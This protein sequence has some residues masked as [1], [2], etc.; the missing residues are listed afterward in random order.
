[1]WQKEGR[2]KTRQFYLDTNVFISQL[3][4]DD[5]YHAEALIIGRKLRK[6]EIHAETSVLTIL[7]T[8]AVA[9][10][11]YHQTMGSEDEDERKAFVAK[12]LRMLAGLVKFVHIDGESPLALGTVKVRVPN[13]FNEALLLGVRTTL[14]TLDIMQV[15]AARHAKQNNGE[16]G[17]FVT[18]DDGILRLKEELSVMAGMPF[19]SPRE[20]VRG[21]DLK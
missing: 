3:K 14:R 7:E 2:D 21:L 9:G 6:G 11:M 1:M 13:I 8:A 20:Y 18:G 16:L 17:A 12:T 4:P 15:A 19:L 10:R 5:P